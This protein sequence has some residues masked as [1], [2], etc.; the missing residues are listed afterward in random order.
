MPKGISELGRWL[1]ERQ[2]EG[3]ELSAAASWPATRAHCGFYLGSWGGGL[4]N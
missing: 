3:I 1:H 4:S 2:A